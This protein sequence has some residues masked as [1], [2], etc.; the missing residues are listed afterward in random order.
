MA[1]ATTRPAQRGGAQFGGA[2]M[3]ATRGGTKN[4]QRRAAQPEFQPARAS[5]GSRSVSNRRT[6]RRCRRQASAP[7][8]RAVGRAASTP[9]R[10]RILPA[11]QSLRLE[12]RSRR[13]TRH[14]SAPLWVLATRARLPLESGAP[15]QWTR[16]VELSEGVRP[17]WR[18]VTFFIVRPPSEIQAHSEG[19]ARLRQ[20][21][22]CNR[23]TLASARV[24]RTSNPLA[25]LGKLT[26]VPPFATAS[27]EK[28]RALSIAALPTRRVGTG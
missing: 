1:S 10:S 9:T 13:R 3:T 5:A 26:S 11:L 4:S 23:R 14:R 18:K 24:R 28:C 12:E 15:V 20:V 21:A 6:H 8:C 17:P 7:R 19:R 2:G 22:N 25:R 27:R 16:Q